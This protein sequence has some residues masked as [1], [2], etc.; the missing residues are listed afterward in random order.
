MRTKEIKRELITLRATMRLLI[1]ATVHWSP[2][3]RAD[4]STRYA[5]FSARIR[6]CLLSEHGPMIKPYVR[7]V[8][9]LSMELTR[10]HK[11]YRYK[12]AK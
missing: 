9:N 11:K 6:F 2:P 7:R 10:R 4:K 8:F 12:N 1:A 3:A 5:Y